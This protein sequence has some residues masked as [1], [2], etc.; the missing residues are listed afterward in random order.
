MPVP[1]ASPKKTAASINVRK[2]ALY[3]I[4]Q[5]NASNTL[6]M[7]GALLKSRSSV[8]VPSMAGETMNA[9]VMTTARARRMPRRMIP[10]TATPDQ[11]NSRASSGSR[12]VQEIPSRRQKRATVYTR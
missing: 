3:L 6:R 9:R 5:P 1:T 10:Y 12:L 4:N 2:P 7:N 8:S 11:A